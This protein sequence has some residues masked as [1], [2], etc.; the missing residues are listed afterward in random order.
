MRIGIDARMLG[1]GFGLARYTEQLV[2]ELL[3]A[4]IDDEIVLFV[5]KENLEVVEK[6]KNQKKANHKNAENIVSAPKTKIVLADIPWYSIKEQT[7]LP[8]LIKK[9]NL[10]IMHFPHWNIPYFCSTPYIVTIH[11]LI[12]FHHKRRGATTHGP[13]IYWLKD[14]AH[15]ILIKKVTK[16]AKHIITTTEFTKQDVAKTLS[17]SLE[18]MTTIYQAPFEGETDTDSWEDVLGRFNLNLPYVL[19]VGHAYPHKNIKGLLK[20]WKRFE[21]EYGTSNYQ[22]VLVGKK[23]IFW[24]KLLDSQEMKECKNV[25]Y[26]G[27]VDDLTLNTLYIQSSLYVHPSLFEGFG[28]PPL[29][30]LKHG[31]PVV[32][33]NRSCLPEI[34]GEAAIYVDPENVDQFAESIYMGL[35]DEDTRYVL[36]QKGKE[37]LKRYSWKKF[38]NQT[39]DT[40][41]KIGS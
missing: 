25:V 39:I 19:F 33:S 21:D 32:S 2:K 3:K 29:E 6:L 18:K 16:K 35:T 8:F 38:I 34:L 5:T 13:L 4:D 27:F 14:R 30:A 20:A 24:Q 40:Y 17:V 10:D 11:D 7:K 15:R 37:E 26:T 23:N 1:K 22:L 9:E 36:K 28:L 41:E 12:M 31:I